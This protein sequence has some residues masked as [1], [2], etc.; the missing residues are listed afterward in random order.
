MGE[1]NTPPASVNGP[2]AAGSDRGPASDPATQTFRHRV[3]ALLSIGVVLLLV[4]ALRVS[5]AVSLPLAAAIIL[6][7]VV[8]PVQRWAR[9]HLPRRIRWLGTVAA[10]ATVVVVTGLLVTA[11]GFAVSALVMR[12]PAYVEEVRGI[13]SSAREWA[14]ARGTPLLPAPTMQPGAGLPAWLT[15][16]LTSGL[17]SLWSMVAG[18][19]LVFFFTLLL[20]LE[21]PRWMEKTHSA[22]SRP[23]ARKLLEAGQVS[24]AKIRRYLLTQATVGLVAAI[25]HGLFLWLMGVELALTWALLF[26]VLNFVPTIG[27]IIAGIPPIVVALATLGLGQALLVAGGVLLIEQV[28]GNVISPRVQGRQLAVS[29]LVV[30][31]SIVFWGWVWGVVGAVLGV[32]LTVT[33]LIACAHYE[34]LR[35]IALLLS[36]TASEDELIRQTHPKPT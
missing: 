34:P 17:T 2:L 24:A 10:M 25:A 22:V 30:L 29:P 12:L 14:T 9:G 1:Q 18:L 3:V 31:V 33:L 28:M 6:A 32:P 16:W 26:F 19:V 27:S 11:M 4:W 23:S 13:A 5:W 20:L 35:P 15:G 36:N 7:V 8:Y 21:A